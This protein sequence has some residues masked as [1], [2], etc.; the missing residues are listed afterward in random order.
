[1]EDTTLA[2]KKASSEHMKPQISGK[3]HQGLARRWGR[4]VIRKFSTLAKLVVRALLPYTGL[5]H[6]QGLACMARWRQHCSM[7]KA[8]SGKDGPRTCVQTAPSCFHVGR[9]LL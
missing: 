8:P 7:M 2:L 9:W 4:G 1:M 3:S 6:G 5:S